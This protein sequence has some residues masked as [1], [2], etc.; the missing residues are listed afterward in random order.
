MAQNSQYIIPDIPIEFNERST[1]ATCTKS[2]SG[3]PRML[4]FTFP[5]PDDAAY[6][7]GYNGDSKIVFTYNES[8]GSWQFAGWIIQ[9]Q[10]AV[11]NFAKFLDSQDLRPL[12][13]LKSK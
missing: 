9:H 3:K 5:D 2:L 1:K 12:P 6:I 13:P 7:A 11:K 8:E 10:N 4:I